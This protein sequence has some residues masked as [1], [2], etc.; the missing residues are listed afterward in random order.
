MARMLLALT[1]VGVMLALAAPAGSAAPEVIEVDDSDE[2]SC[3]IGH[4]VTGT[5][6]VRFLRDGSEL[7]TINLTHTLTFPDGTVVRHKD[8]GSDLFVSTGDDTATATIRGNLL[9]VRLADGTVLR[10]A[11]RSIVELTFVGENQPP[12]EVYVWNAGP[13][14][15]G[16]FGEAICAAWEAS[17]D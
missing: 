5:V 3:G 15:A 10:D 16:D 17:Q 9:K 11:G 7:A 8:T 1:T 14:V 4:D 13:K 12:L 6:R 2:L